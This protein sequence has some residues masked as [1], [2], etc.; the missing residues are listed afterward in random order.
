MIDGLTDQVKE[1]NGFKRVKISID[2]WRNAN[3]LQISYGLSAFITEYAVF[4]NG[5]FPEAISVY[6]N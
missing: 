6:A 2:N 5:Y 1:V 4:I 3:F